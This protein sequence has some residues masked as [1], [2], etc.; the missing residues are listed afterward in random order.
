MN[1]R[2]KLGSLCYRVVCHTTSVKCNLI[3]AERSYNLRKVTLIEMTFVI[4]APGTQNRGFQTFR[5]KSDSV[6]SLKLR[7][8]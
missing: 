5:R 8:I 3:P 2:T 4:A 6:I 7:K 1:S